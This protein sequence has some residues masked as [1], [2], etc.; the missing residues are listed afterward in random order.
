[1]SLMVG[2]SVGVGLAVVVVGVLADAADETN[3]TDTAD[4]TD[5]V[6]EVGVAG[7]AA[8]ERAGVDAWCASALLLGRGAGLW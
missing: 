7:L 5:V 3:G 1:M 4:G 2:W 8:E 6:D